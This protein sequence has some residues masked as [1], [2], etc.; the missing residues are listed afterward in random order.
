MMGITIAVSN[1]AVSFGGSRDRNAVGALRPR[2]WS[3]RGVSARQSRSPIERRLP[4]AP[5]FPIATERRYFHSS[6][7]SRVTAGAAGFWTFTQQS[8]RP[9]R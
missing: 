4:A 7:A 3:G 2:R 1:H 6:S 9:E 8:A 5:P